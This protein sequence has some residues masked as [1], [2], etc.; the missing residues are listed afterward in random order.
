M[1]PTFYR[2]AADAIAA[3]PEEVAYMVAFDRAGQKNDAMTVIDV[4]PGSKTYG[5][6]VGW[7]DAHQ[8]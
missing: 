5:R 1:D 4:K 3:P 6:V 8:P 7:T 2:T